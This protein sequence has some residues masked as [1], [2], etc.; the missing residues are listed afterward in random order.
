MPLE[1]LLAM[2]GYSVPL[3]EREEEAEASPQTS[4]TS[5]TRHT[6]PTSTTSHSEPSHTPSPSTQQDTEGSTDSPSHSPHPPQLIHDVANDHNLAEEV[7]IGEHGTT[8]SSSSVLGKHL[9]S[10]ELS[11]DALYKD[12][13][14]SSRTTP[15]G[16]RTSM[17]DD[18]LK[19]FI[20]MPRLCVNCT[21][22]SRTSL[23]R[24]REREREMW[25]ESRYTGHFPPSTTHMFVHV[26]NNAFICYMYMN[27]QINIL[28]LKA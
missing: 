27:L 13:M 10:G 8:S 1:Q 5:R 12:V 20:R 18:T 16:T 14:L 25:D 6:N 2:Y 26:Y 11:D 23:Q 22:L 15:E 17:F 3:K 21:I 9:R 4:H 19:S 28:L 7:E 24:E